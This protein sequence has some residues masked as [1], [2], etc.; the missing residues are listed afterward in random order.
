MMLSHRSTGALLRAGCTALLA[1][2]ACSEAPAAETVLPPGFQVGPMFVAPSLVAGLF[3]DSN[4]F[5]RSPESVLPGEQLDDVVLRLNPAIIATLPFRNSWFRFGYDGVFRHYRDS[6]TT[7][8]NSQDV[9]VE[10][11]MLFSTFDRWT[12]RADRSWGA[13]D[14]IRFDGGEAVSDGTP[15]TFVTYETVVERD[16]PGRRGYAANL[17][18]SQ[19]TFDSTSYAFFEYEGPEGSAEL[20]EALNPHLWFVA[21]VA[22]RRF[23]HRLANDPTNSVYRQERTDAV[24]AGVQGLTPSGQSWRAVLRYDRARYPGASTGSDYSGL[25]GEAYVFLAPGPTSTVSFYASR[26]SWS[27]FYLD[28]NYYVANVLGCRAEKRWMNNTSVGLDAYASLTDYPEATID[29]LANTSI[30]RRDHLVWGQLYANLGI[31]AFY[32][33]RFTYVYQSRNSNVEGVDYR[34]NAFGVQFVLGVR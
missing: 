25:G 1:A 19:L 30:A 13:A 12:I 21:G 14:V 5:L 22:F 31:G 27:S 26:R 2:W 23:D 34:G 18:Y 17:R 3:V 16:V 29:P 4:P 10:L 8:N 11:S 20:R 6:T 7:D 28:N 9:V 24:L 33:F 32:A 15:F